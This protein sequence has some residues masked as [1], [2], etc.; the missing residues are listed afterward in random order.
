MWYKQWI[1]R[2]FA[3][4]CMHLLCDRIGH[5]F[6]RAVMWNP[7]LINQTLSKTSDRGAVKVL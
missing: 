6:Q 2:S 7:I 1:L 5:L 3:H 4:W